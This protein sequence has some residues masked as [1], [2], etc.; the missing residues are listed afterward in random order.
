MPP[1]E[2]RGHWLFVPEGAGEWAADPK[3]LWEAAGRAER[4]YDA[5]EGRFLDL[6]VPRGVPDALYPE[7]AKSMA[8]PFVRDGLPVQVDWHVRPACDGEPNTHLHCLIGARQIV[9]GAFARSKTAVRHWNRAFRQRGP[10]GIRNLIAERL[11][12]FFQRHDLRI[13]IDPR[14]N[15]ERGLPPAEPRLPRSV[16]R[17][18]DTAYSLARLAERDQHRARRAAWAAAVDAES[19]AAAAVGAIEDEIAVLKSGLI[20]VAPMGPTLSGQAQFAICASWGRENEIEV[21]AVSGAA[22]LIR[23]EGC[24]LIVE[25]DGAFV[26]GPLDERRAAMF[27]ELFARLGWDAVA[28]EGPPSDERA[29]LERAV[30][31]YWLL[32]RPVESREDDLDGFPSPPAPSATAPG[33]AAGAQLWASYRDGLRREMDQLRLIPPTGRRSVKRKSEPVDEPEASIAEHENPTPSPS[34]S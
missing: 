20:Q 17:R 28:I 3:R 11:N 19:D 10:G 22:T 26:D 34:S 33:A 30:D 32:K 21:E 24:E 16:I 1:G 14:T 7:L 5:Q 6:Q 25:S 27:S 4:Q 8:Q 12:S 9:D 18:P 29:R 23:A 31:L 15:C 2:C 13:H